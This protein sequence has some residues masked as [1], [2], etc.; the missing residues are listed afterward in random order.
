MK[1]F[2]AAIFCL[3]F[4]L[5]VNAQVE[6]KYDRFKDETSVSV[7]L[8]RIPMDANFNSLVWTLDTKF[9]GQVVPADPVLTM[10]ILISSKEWRFLRADL[11][12]RGIIDGER[13]T[14][15]DFKRNYSE[16]VRGAVMEGA[17]AIVSIDTLRRMAAAKKI[18]AQFMG[19]EMQ[20]TQWEQKQIQAFLDALKP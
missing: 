6:K 14:I 4:G 11:T 2:F 15:A 18:E 12:M 13:M 1:L 8:G 19:G 17:G 5:M 7:V 16:T 10:Y 9:S 20:A 3:A